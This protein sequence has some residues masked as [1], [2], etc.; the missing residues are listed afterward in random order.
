[1]ATRY[2]TQPRGRGATTRGRNR[3]YDY[4]APA[5]M[6]GRK[7]GLGS[8]SLVSDQQRKLPGTA[9]YS[10]M[11]S[12][13]RQAQA[14]REIAAQRL[15]DRQRGEANARLAANARAQAMVTQRYGGSQPARPPATTSFGG[16][17]GGGGGGNRV[18]GGTT[19][20]GTTGGKS[21]STTK[22]KPAPVDDIDT[23]R[24]KALQDALAAIAAQFGMTDA[25]LKMQLGDLSNYFRQQDEVIT[26]QKDQAKRAA[27]EDA[28]RRGIGRSSIYEGNVADVIEQAADAKAQLAQEYGTEA[29]VGKGRAGSRARQIQSALKLLVQQKQTAQTQAKTTS[30][31]GQLDLESL[32]AL[33]GTGIAGTDFAG[34]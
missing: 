23:A 21:S 25:E 4:Q 20:G 19:G 18:G 33:I 34:V 32:L 13:Y 14:A 31:K 2:R 26:E 24:Q 5:T 7:T 3:R 22:P 1:M 28:V 9:R 27:I 8:V 6:G 17:G 10:A 15:R 30:A 11:V 29:T 16:G 12:S